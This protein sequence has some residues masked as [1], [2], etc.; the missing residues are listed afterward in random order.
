MKTIGKFI[1]SGHTFIVKT[2]KTESKSN[3]NI[4]CHV[5][6]KGIKGTLVGTTFKDTDTK[7]KIMNWA[8]RSLGSPESDLF[9]QLILNR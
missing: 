2:Q 3:Y 5:C 1:Q 4:F 7:E 9:K 6:E 8:S